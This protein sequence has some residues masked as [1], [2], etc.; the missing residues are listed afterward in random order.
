MQGLV[1]RL[2]FKYRNFI[3]YSV[4]GL[5][6]VSINYVAFFILVHFFNIHYQVAN[7][8]SVSMGIT[9]NFIL[10]SRYNFKV[11]DILMKRFVSFYTIGLF[12]LLV[13]SSL[14]YLFHKIWGI[15]V[16]V[17]KAMTLVFVV[18]LQFF[19]NRKFT[20]RVLKNEEK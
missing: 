8:I 13:S 6:G 14:L 15:N 3:L 4:I 20:F 12:G 5:T 16:F 2:C 11:K 1:K 7:F 9:N 10:N 19:L 17:S 18:I